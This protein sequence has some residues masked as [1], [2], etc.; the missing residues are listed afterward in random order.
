MSNIPS[1]SALRPGAAYTDQGIP[2]TSAT[3][4]Y[5]PVKVEEG[6]ISRDSWMTYI[7]VFIVIVVIAYLILWALRP[8]WLRRDDGSIDVGK[9]LG[10]AVVIGVVLVLIWW[11]LRSCSRPY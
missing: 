8:T 6:L 2:V 10:A 9:T 1:L 4:T 11:A 5:Y 7:I 3:T